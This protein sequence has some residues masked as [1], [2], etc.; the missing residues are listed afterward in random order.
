MIKKINIPKLRYADF[1]IVL[2]P[3]EDEL[4]S[5]WLVRMAYAHQT[6]PHTFT[7]QYLGYRYNS[8]FRRDPDV[9]M[10]P[11]IIEKLDQMCRGRVDINS[12]TLKTFAGYLQEEIT[13]VP[14]LFLCALRFCPACLRAD[15]IPYFRRRWR[16]AFYTVCLEHEC[17]LEDRCPKCGK[18]LEISKMC[19][20]PQFSD[21][22]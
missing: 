1:L 20:L 7:N 18:K 6:H 9:S 11:S 15:R 2:T 12:L 21:S 8:F 19:K 16:V 13:D 10:V 5:S 14:N 22:R 3:L 17:Y 4:F